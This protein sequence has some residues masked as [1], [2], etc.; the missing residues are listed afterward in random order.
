[1]EGTI[2]YMPSARSWQ[3]QLAGKSLWV[4]SLY[5]V[6]MPVCQTQISGASH[7]RR[8]RLF[9]DTIQLHREYTMFFSVVQEKMRCIEKS[10]QAGF[11]QKG[12]DVFR[13]FSI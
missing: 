5:A 12:M 2:R 6:R 8:F 3:L 10:T 4:R 7:V 13:I 11:L 1:M 9:W